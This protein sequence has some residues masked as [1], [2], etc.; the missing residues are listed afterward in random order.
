VGYGEELKNALRAFNIERV[1][2]LINEL[3]HFLE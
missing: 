2:E 3:K 1:N